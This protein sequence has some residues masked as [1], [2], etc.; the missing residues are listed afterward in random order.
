MGTEMAKY[1]FSNT[2]YIDGDRDGKVRIQQYTIYRWR[3]GWQSTH[4]EIQDIQMGIGMAE[5]AFSNARDQDGD[6]D[7]KACILQEVKAADIKKGSSPEEEDH[8]DTSV[9]CLDIRS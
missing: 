9:W 5:Y 1:A 2:R 8:E 4:S 6:R 3:Q 7:G